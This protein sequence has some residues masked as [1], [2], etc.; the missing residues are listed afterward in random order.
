VIRDF[1]EIGLWP[2]SRNTCSLALQFRIDLL[3]SIASPYWFNYADGS[4]FH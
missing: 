2:G 4:S 3:V 1:L